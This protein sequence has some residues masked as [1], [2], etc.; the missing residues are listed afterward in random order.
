MGHTD[1]QTYIHTDVVTVAGSAP[2]QLLLQ[3]GVTFHGKREKEI[4]SK[5][6][7]LE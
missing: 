1:V 5:M 4:S 3:R 6:E 7:T 2:V